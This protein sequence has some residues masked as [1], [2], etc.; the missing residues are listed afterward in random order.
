MH[1]FGL[2]KFEGGEL[3]L[4]GTMAE[5]VRH[6]YLAH[7]N[8]SFP[9]R[10]DRVEIEGVRES[11]GTLSFGSQLCHIS[12]LSCLVPALINLNKTIYY[13]ELLTLLKS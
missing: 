8:S 3:R 13:T 2:F 5:I 9:V 11:N 12:L 7:L 1:P 6:R 4:K 10:K